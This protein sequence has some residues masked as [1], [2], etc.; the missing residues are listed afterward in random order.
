[1]MLTQDDALAE[2]CAGCMH[3]ARQAT[4]TIGHQQPA[5]TLQ[6]PCFAK[7][8]FLESWNRLRREKAHWYAGSFGIRP[9]HRRRIRRT[10]IFHQYTIRVPKR[11]RCSSIQ[12]H[13]M[14]VPCTLIS[15]CSPA[16]RTSAIAPEG[17]RKPSAP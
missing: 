2:L 13:G 12:A 10:S 7:L 1:M 15:I 16:S 17:C 14:D 6:R 8:P 9:L 3:G 11:M 5:D 4:T